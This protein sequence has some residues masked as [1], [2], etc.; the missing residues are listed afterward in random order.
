M[1]RNGLIRQYKSSR[2]ALQSYG[3]SFLLNWTLNVERLL[4][5]PPL[6]RASSSPYSFFSALCPCFALRIRLL[7]VRR[8]V[9]STTNL[10]RE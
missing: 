9:S 10:E 1:R 4:L 5:S 3:S 2:V 6:S 8:F 7:K